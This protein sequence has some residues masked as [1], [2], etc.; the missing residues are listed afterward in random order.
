MSDKARDE[1]E[2]YMRSTVW[3]DQTLFWDGERYFSGEADATYRGWLAAK[4]KY[5]PR[6]IPVSERLPEID[7]YVVWSCDD[8]Y[9][10]FAERDKDDPDGYWE[11]RFTHWAVINPPSTQGGGE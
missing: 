11:E 2:E 1:F 4:E 7:Q 9:M 8:G 5:E 6:W 10:I 3:D